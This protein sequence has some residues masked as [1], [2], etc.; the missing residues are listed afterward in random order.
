MKFISD[1]LSL[2]VPS[3]AFWMTRYFRG[4]LSMEF[5]KYFC[6]FR[7]S[8]HFSEH[9]GRP[10]SARWAKR[11]KSRFL[12]LEKAHEDARK[13]LDFELLSEIEMGNLKVKLK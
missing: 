9:T 11:M 12:R 3:E 13:S 6:A 7:S 5:L 2:P 4:E 10:C 1:F 8:F